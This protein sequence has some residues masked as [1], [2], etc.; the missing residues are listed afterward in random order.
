MS[1]RPET[2]PRKMDALK[3][4]SCLMQCIAQSIY[5][6]TKGEHYAKKSI[7]TELPALSIVLLKCVNNSIILRSRCD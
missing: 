4:L 3:I 6:I 7:I 1:G 2:Y 5:N